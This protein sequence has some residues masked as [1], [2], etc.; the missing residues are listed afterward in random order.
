MV[1]NIRIL[2]KPTPKKLRAF[3]VND[4]FDLHRKWRLKALES[5]LLQLMRSSLNTQTP[6]KVLDGASTVWSVML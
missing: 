1:T 2:N 3:S 6:I 4:V 5:Q